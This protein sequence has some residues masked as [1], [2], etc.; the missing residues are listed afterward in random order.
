MATMN[1]WMNHCLII[2]CSRHHKRVLRAKW[3]NSYH[4]MCNCWSGNFWLLSCVIFDLVMDVLIIGDNFALQCSAKCVVCNRRRKN[5]KKWTCDNVCVSFCHLSDNEKGEKM[6]LKINWMFA[7]C[8]R[9]KF[10]FIT[11]LD[12]IFVAEH[13]AINKRVHTVFKNLPQ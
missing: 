1:E 11:P 10:A 4:K 2:T 12:E 9:F 7:F 5:V 8:K 13:T 6:R 3:R